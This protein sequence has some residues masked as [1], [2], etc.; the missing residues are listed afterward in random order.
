MFIESGIPL[1]Q[2]ANKTNKQ[3]NKQTSKQKQKYFSLANDQ[4]DEN[5]ILAFRFLG[6]D[7]KK[8]K[9]HL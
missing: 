2:N 3:T 1:K 8:M 6:K 4:L 9:A 7:K 5:L